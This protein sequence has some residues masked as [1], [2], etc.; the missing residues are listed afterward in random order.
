MYTYMYILYIIL[1]PIARMYS[2]LYS[3]STR[4]EG[5]GGST[6]E[7]RCKCGQ[8][9]QG[10]I[11]ASLYPN[12]QRKSVCSTLHIHVAP[13]DPTGQ[14]CIVLHNFYV[15]TPTTSCHGDITHALAVCSRPSFSLSAL[16]Q[17]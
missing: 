13:W 15:Y 8:P 11:Q 2:A 3:K 17:G 14:H 1:P 16:L 4:S 9:K 6:V 10:N 5:G 12:P 7:Q